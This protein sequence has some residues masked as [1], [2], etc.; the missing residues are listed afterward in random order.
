MMCKSNVWPEKYKNR[1]R[2]AYDAYDRFIAEVDSD[3]APDFSR[4]EQ[5]S[6]VV[7]GATQVGKTTLILDLLG[8]G[9]KSLPVV[10]DVLRGGQ[11]LGK[12]STASPIR[13]GRSMDALW[14]I[15]DSHGLGDAEA[16]EQL[17]HIRA[18]V[19][20]G[21]A[22][23]FEIINVRIPAH[24][25]EA[26]EEGTLS[27]KLQ[28]LDIPGINAINQAEQEQVERIVRQ[29]VTSADL[30]LLVG[31][32]DNLGFLHPNAL[33]LDA[34]NDWMLLPNRFRVVLTYTFSPASFKSW[35]GTGPRTAQEVRAH[36]Y[37]E[38]QT[39]DY[40]PPPSVEHIV[41]PLEFGDSLE[42]LKKDGGDGYYQRASEVIAEL[43][44]ELIQSIEESASPY[45]RLHSAFQVKGFIE[46]K[47]EREQ[48]EH[49][50]TMRRLQRASDEVQEA[51]DSYLGLQTDFSEEA[52]T[53]RREA[54][55]L[56]RYGALKKR[57]DFSR[58]FI[59]SLPSCAESVSALTSVAH[60]FESR[61]L[62][63]W[64]E[65]CARYLQRRGRSDGADL[66]V[67]STAA[68]APFFQKMD[69]YLTDSYWWS[70]ENFKADVRM[71]N[72]AAREVMDLFATTANDHAVQLLKAKEKRHSKEH[73]A[74]AL[75]QKTVQQE[76]AR[77]KATLSSTIELIT[78]AQSAHDLFLDRT[79]KSLEHAQ[80][81]EDYIHQAFRHEVKTVQGAIKSPANS[82][83]QV[84]DIFY[85][86]VLLGE[87]DKMPSREDFQ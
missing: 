59:Q 44:K 55:A 81:F 61:I 36:S 24:Y 38:L 76:V 73:Q 43:R 6:I 10:S 14:Y 11:R 45:A 70:S 5:V 46:A 4:S 18:Q 23:E 19:E 31:R 65:H 82:V 49:E 13:Y 87:L 32:S 71:L 27:R 64:A 7:Y 83:D 41:F 35:F 16:T 8:V 12:S 30:I 84:Y 47:V 9:S 29:Y 54:T 50:V 58:V 42:G 21:T 79:R 77:R 80:K 28:I 78:C 53:L 62:A 26:G 22:T 86:K 48:R 1:F 20:S 37:K 60:R 33:K 34:L 52:F 3:F 2:W 74:F 66:Q 57:S 69:G 75:R 17:A 85:L 25:F 15:D 72:H 40:A 67:P 51:L 39:H 56:R 63:Q 68:L